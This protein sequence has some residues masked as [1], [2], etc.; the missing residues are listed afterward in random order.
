VIFLCDT[1]VVLWWARRS[2]RLSAAVRAVLEDAGTDVRISPVVPWELSIKYHLGK[3][4]EAEPLVTAWSETFA[5][6]GAGR[7]P[8]ADAH[9]ILSGALRWEHRDPFDRLLAAQAVLEGATVLSADPVFD[10]VAGVR[11]LW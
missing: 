2:T 10:A 3:L 9:V 1:H 5:R 4:P 7:L 8:I 11:R 6:L